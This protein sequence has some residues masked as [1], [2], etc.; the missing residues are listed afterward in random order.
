MKKFR[1]LFLVILTLS[2]NYSIILAQTSSIMMNEIYSRGTTTDP[3]WI[4][5]YNSSMK[6]IDISGYKI[7]DNGGQGGTKPKMEFPVNTVI[8]AKGYYVIVTDISTTTNPA[9]FGLSSGGEKVWLEDKSGTII[10]TITFA[11]MADTQTYSRYP[12][13]GAWKLVNALTKG[14]A[15]TLVV[16]NEIYSRGTTTDPDWIEIYNGSGKAVDISGY[17]IYD[18]GGQG[19]TKPK[20]ELASGT[21]I[22]SKGFYVIVTDISTTTNPAGFGLSSSGE[23]V[24]LEDKS[25]TIIDT[26]TFAAMT[27]TQSYGRYPD[28]ISWSLLSPLTKNAKNST[29]TAIHGVTSAVKDFRLD[30][31]YPNPFNPSTTINFTLAKE[32]YV[33]ISVYD[34]NGKRIKTLIDKNMQS[35]NYT[36]AWDARNEFNTSLAS[37]KYYYTISIDNKIMATRSMLFLK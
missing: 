35:G 16:M 30:Q 9:G 3:D 28:G 31:N 6:T 8:P 21:T 2:I 22:A 13:G 5:I 14:S 7:Y 37:G 12:D 26:I 32:G 11:A 10:D 17:K 15:N 24:W 19:G 29:P 18:N 27:E 34:L 23:K 4:E 33:N 20:M 1:F 36:I 25:G